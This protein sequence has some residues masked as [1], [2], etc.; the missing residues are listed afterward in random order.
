MVQRWRDFDRPN[1]ARPSACIPYLLL[2]L[3][4]ATARSFVR[5]S[6]RDSLDDKKI[7]L[8]LGVDAWKEL[9]IFWVAR[10][11]SGGISYSLHTLLTSIV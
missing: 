8:E 3:F 11:T 1:S 5:R 2:R 6:V 10:W 4:A 7:V 9:G